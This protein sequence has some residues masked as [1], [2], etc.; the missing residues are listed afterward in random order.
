MRQEFANETYIDHTSDN[1]P[2]RGY[3]NKGRARCEDGKIRAMKIHNDPDTYFSV[4][5]K[6]QI[7]G[8]TI[9]GFVMVI[10]EELVFTAR[11]GK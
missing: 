3:F 6:T 2:Y 5:A 11:N 8:K 4:M 7:N 1:C 9:T 10:D